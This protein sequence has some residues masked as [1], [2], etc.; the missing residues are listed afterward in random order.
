MPVLFF[1]AIGLHQYWRFRTGR[2]AAAYKGV[3]NTAALTVSA[4][5]AATVAAL[6]GLRPYAD[7]NG[8]AI[9]ALTLAAGV[10]LGLSAL[11]V[12]GLATVEYH[13]RAVRVARSMIRTKVP[14]AVGNVVVGVAMIAGFGVNRL[15]F[16][17]LPPALWLLH[18]T[19]AYRA[20]TEDERRSWQAFAEATRELNH[21]HE[22]QAAAAG[23]DG[24]ARLFAARCAEIV[25]DNPRRVYTIN[26]DGVVTRTDTPGEC[27][28]SA[29]D[30]RWRPAPC[31]WVAPV[32]ASCASCRPTRSTVATRSCSTRTVTRSPRPCTTPR[33]TA[34]CRRSPSAA[35]TTPTTTR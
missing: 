15:W 3:N 26:A 35:T 21:L 12:A 30:R 32:S 14:M 33:P 4:A 18:Q 2:I 23:L 19:F 16:L 5:G 11:I 31:S 1:V 28:E 8:H 22:N 10:F 20:T 9:F 34:S 24:A 17:A 25:L 13:Q 27:A 6:V 29:R 7:L